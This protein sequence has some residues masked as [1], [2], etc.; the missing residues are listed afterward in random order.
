[1][2]RPQPSFWIFLKNKIYEPNLILL[3][4]AFFIFIFAMSVFSSQ[5]SPARPYVPLVIFST[6]TL[7]VI[8]CVIR[9]MFA[10]KKFQELSS[11]FACGT[12]TIGEIIDIYF[13]R[14]SGY[15]TYEYQYQQEKYRSTDSVNRNRKTKELNVG[16]KVMLYV[17]QE[18]LSQAYIRDLYLNTF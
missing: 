8:G 1:M 10:R 3:P 2:S 4:W 15:V 13:S 5:P 9:L 7:F 6:S 12:E 11:I 14:G 16:Q 18:K 17:N